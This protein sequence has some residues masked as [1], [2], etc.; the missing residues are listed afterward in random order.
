MAWYIPVQHILCPVAGGGGGG[1]GG[2]DC[3]LCGMED[4]RDLTHNADTRIT[5]QTQIT[6]GM[7]GTG[8]IMHHS[9]RYKFSYRHEMMHN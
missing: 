8:L 4:Q 5:I 3:C 1:G 6:E 7:V 2:G 9:T